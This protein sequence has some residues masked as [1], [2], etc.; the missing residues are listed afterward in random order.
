MKVLKSL[1][2]VL[3][4]LEK[5]RAIVEMSSSIVHAINAFWEG[6]D[7]NREKLTIDG[8]SLL[9]IYIYAT[10]KSEMKDLFAQIKFVND[11]ST[12][13]VKSTKLGYCTTT[14]EVA[15]NHILMLSYE[16]LFPSHGPESQPA[17]NQE[18]DIMLSQVSERKNPSIIWNEAR[19][20]IA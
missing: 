12:P 5:S 17:G 15:I 4:P 20:S 14:L 1:K 11:F 10:I 3:A 8:D 7:I 6:L 16:E 9:M 19:K 18:I 2:K 13:Y